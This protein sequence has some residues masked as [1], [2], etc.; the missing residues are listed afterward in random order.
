[1]MTRYQERFLTRLGML[2]ALLAAFA[3]RVHRLGTQELRGDE[4]FGYFFS[5]RPFRDIVR[6]TLALAEPH[7]VASYF[8]EKAWIAQAGDT[9][10]ALRFASL[11]FGVVAVALIFRL[12]RRLGLSQA[13]SLTAA[14][15]MSIS[16]YAIWHSQDAR[17]YAMSLA[18]SVASVWLA[19]EAVLRPRLGSWLAY[20][21]ITL[22][23]LHTHYFAA[24]VILAQNL[25]VLT[26]ALAGPGRR[27]LAPWLATQ[28]ALALLY[29]PW[30]VAVSDI[31]A[32]YG[33]NGDSPA[34]VEMLIRSLSVFAV[35]EMVP[36]QQRPL[37]ALLAATLLVLGV[38]SL[39]VRPSGDGEQ[40]G[41]GQRWA[42]WLLVLYL[43]VPLGT[44]WLSSQ[45]RPL[46]NER[47]L[48][49]ASPPF[50]LL[51]AQGFVGGGSLLAPRG[52]A[53][54]KVWQLTQAIL[55]TVWLV[56]GLLSLNR[57]Y[58]DPD[59]S[60]TRGWRELAVRL[61][62]LA[63]GVSRESTRLIQN[64]PDPTLW[65]YYRGPRDHIVLP[66]RAHDDAG[67]RLEVQ[68]LQ[69]AG[70]SRAILAV[71][72]A[73][74]WDDSG[75]AQKALATAY[76][77]VAE[78]TIG[79][80]PVQVYS[81][82]EPNSLEP[83]GAGFENRVTL[84]DASWEPT[85]PYSASPGGVI[86]VHLNWSGGP[87]TLTGTEKLFLHL[88]DDTGQPLAQ[89]DPPLTPA[90]LE[91]P[92]VSYGLLLPETL[93]PGTY[94]L[95]AGL[96]DPAQDGSPRIPTVEGADTVDLGAVSVQ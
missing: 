5:L 22:L 29:L 77:P 43:A 39:L 52:H 84:E 81:R 61:E 64:F 32:Q 44:T 68:A 31:L 53:W 3:L 9:E 33:G 16:P 15:L 50:L 96:Y 62:Q 70:V 86:V 63:A 60:K 90:T 51:V 75:L 1:M 28:L 88:V 11:W 85:A 71:Q 12:G 69:E 87:D 20:L 49:A 57:L 54:A 58:N 17:M 82:H 35:G 41:L 93:P 36:I 26:W 14:V 42:L 13:T 92:Q 37:L 27:Q 95:I 78:A 65:Y 40:Q 94:R 74:W 2:L 89:A 4:A 76:T 30:L 56:A 73:P 59:Y 79:A 83:V 46:F 8:L 80:W 66:P 24:F 25:F 18:L 45:S 10:A 7:P 91:A 67:A 55:V 34:L 72:P 47:Y 38:A 21:L 23:A 6:S 19:L 48:I